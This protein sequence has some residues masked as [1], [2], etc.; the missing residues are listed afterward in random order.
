MR[1]FIFYP[2]TLGLMA[3]VAG[4]SLLESGFTYEKSEDEFTQEVK[5]IAGAEISG[6]VDNN[7]NVELSFT[8]VSKKNSAE[9]FSPIIFSL[10]VIGNDGKP[11]NFENIE[12][13]LN[14]DEI[15]SFATLKESN[16]SEYV[17]QISMPLDS[18]YFA[19][20]VPMA[21][22]LQLFLPEYLG[23]SLHDKD[24]NNLPNIDKILNSVFNSYNKLNSVSVRYETVDGQVNTATFD[25]TDQNVKSVFKDCGW[26]KYPKMFDEL[27]VSRDK[28]AKEIQAQR[29]SEARA[30]EEQQALE[31][32]EEIQGEVE[33]QQ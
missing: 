20:E 11:Y 12:L 17:N 31:Q 1:K 9:E 18:L 27:K 16:T 8:C 30:A 22:L 24:G 4:C 6:D 7:A 19:G 23:N 2:I 13:K 25:T 26:D 5:S 14:N 28:R 29:A 21:G 15:K 3:S 10:V 33:L 32:Q